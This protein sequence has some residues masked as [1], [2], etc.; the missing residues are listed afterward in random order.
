[1]ENW[2]EKKKGKKRTSL[3]EWESEL[4]AEAVVWLLILV[5]AG[6]FL[7]TNFPWLLFSNDE[8]AVIAC[9][10]AVALETDERLFWVVAISSY[11][12]VAT[13]IM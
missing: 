8:L 12:M 7:A 6:R 10:F 3:E 5:R 4:R 1:M 11:E 2:I 9:L 13:V